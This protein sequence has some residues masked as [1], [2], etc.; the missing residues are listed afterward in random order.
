VVKGYSIWSGKG[1]L[2]PNCQAVCLHKNEGPELGISRKG[3][4]KEKAINTFILI[5]Q[6][7]RVKELGLHLKQSKSRIQISGLESKGNMT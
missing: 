1:W 3:R 5:K 7:G 4:V 2:T 6:K